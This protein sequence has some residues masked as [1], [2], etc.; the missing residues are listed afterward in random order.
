MMEKDRARVSAINRPLREGHGLHLARHDADEEFVDGPGGRGR[1]GYKG[2]TAEPQ[3]RRWPVYVMARA[4][5]QRTVNGLPGQL[6]PD[7]RLRAL[8]ERLAQ[9]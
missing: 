3:G 7:L 4:H 1:V 9:A 8:S 5:Q 2:T 6:Q